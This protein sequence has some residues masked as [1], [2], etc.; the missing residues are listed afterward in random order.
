MLKLRPSGRYGSKYYIPINLYS[1]ALEEKRI[2]GG[3]QSNKYTMLCCCKLGVKQLLNLFEIDY[4][5]S[6]ICKNFG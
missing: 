6:Q 4:E 2:R 1:G 5:T 3:N